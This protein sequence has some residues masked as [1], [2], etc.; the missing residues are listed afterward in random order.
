MSPIA[1]VIRMHDISWVLILM[2]NI[3]CDQVDLEWWFTAVLRWY[4]SIN[5]KQISSHTSM[6]ENEHIL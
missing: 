5:G 4:I 6:T 2:I 3:K 1:K